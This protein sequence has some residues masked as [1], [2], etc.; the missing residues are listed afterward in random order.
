MDLGDIVPDKYFDPLVRVELKDCND[1][2]RLLL[3]HLLEVCN[4]SDEGR[5]K[6]EN[7]LAEFVNN[8]NFSS[9]VDIMDFILN[10]RDNELMPA[11]C[12]QL[13]NIS[14]YKIALDLLYKL[15][16]AEEK[17]YPDRKKEIEKQLKAW[18][19]WNLFRGK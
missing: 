13:N 4:S 17:K 1:Y 7:I 5:V 3:Q 19:K 18:K 12:F 6:I 11:I 16:Q 14:C 8:N 15:E 9:D 10:L 2:F